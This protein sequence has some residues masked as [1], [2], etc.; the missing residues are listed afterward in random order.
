M[1]L[2][3]KPERFQEL[4]SCLG[5]GHHLQPSERKRLA[6]LGQELTTL[7]AQQ[8]VSKV[9]QEAQSLGRPVAEAVQKA[10]RLILAEVMNR[11]S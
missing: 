7:E 3:R 6:A 1:D 10:R 2:W 8:Q 4:L 11:L 9:A 5:L